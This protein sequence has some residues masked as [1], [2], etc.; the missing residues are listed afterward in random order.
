M[1]RA[2]FK[3][4]TACRDC[5]MCTGHAFTGVGRNIGRGAADILT[6]G[7][8]YLARKTCKACD[9]PMSEHA[10]QNAQLVNVA[11]G[12]PS[13]Q[14]APVAAT[15]NPARWV[16]V[17]DGRHRWWNGERWTDYYSAVLTTTAEQIAAARSAATDAPARWKQ[18]PDGR[19]RWWGG[20]AYSDQYTRDPTGEIE[21]A[22]QALPISGDGSTDELMKLAE[23]HKAGVLTARSSRQRRRSCSACRP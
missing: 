22:Q 7:I 16:V 5:Q 20:S 1:A 17:A 2:K 18:Q 15:N 13:T 10:G 19:F 8:S 21:Y 23:L 6:V 12:Q 3:V 11:A 9:Y 4:N 14:A